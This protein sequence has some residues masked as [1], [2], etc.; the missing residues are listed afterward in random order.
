MSRRQ[1]VSL[2]ADD[3]ARSLLLTTLSELVVPA[4][5]PIWTRS[6]LYVLLGL[7]VSEQTS[8]QTLARASNRGWI[9]GERSGREVRW[10]ATRQL[11]D[12]LEELTRRVESLSSPSE[13]WDGNAVFL[14][15]IVPQEKKAVRKRL[16]SALAWA[17]FGNPMPGFWASPHVDRI[18]EAKAAIEELGLQETTIVAIGRLADCGLATREIVERSWNLDGVAD[19]YLELLRKYENLAPESGD[20]VLFSYLSLVHEWRGFPAID[21]QLPRD[22]LPDWIGRKAADT[23]VT[24]RARWEPAMRR[25]W[26]EVIEMTAPAGAASSS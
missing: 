17:G 12:M 4:D 20:E 19:Q 21:P 15:V 8:R 5:E 25:R 7:G 9:E 16:Y 24:L 2:P 23:F 22:V 1:Q 3:S 14:N 26:E 18:S 10:T 13:H 11:E 6:L